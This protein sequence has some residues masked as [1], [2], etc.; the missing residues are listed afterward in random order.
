MGRINGDCFFYDGS[1]TY[2]DM[3]SNSLWNLRSLP[4]IADTLFYIFRIHYVNDFLLFDSH[5]AYYVDVR[6]VTYV[7]NWCELCRMWM[8][9]STLPRHALFGFL[10]LLIWPPC[11]KYNNVPNNC[12]QNILVKW[13]ACKMQPLY[14]VA[15]GP[16]NF[17]DTKPQMSAFLKNWPV[18]GLGGMCLSVLGPLPS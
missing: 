14:R 5:I 8:P 15:H 4:L 16:N 10:K 13:A 18:K 12:W 17:I 6:I 7:G 2:T 1:V 3:S 9:P 11:T